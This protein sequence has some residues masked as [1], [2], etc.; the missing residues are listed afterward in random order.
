MLYLTKQVL[1]FASHSWR[2]FLPAHMPVTILYS[3]QVAKLLGKLDKLGR[4]WNP[5]SMLG[6]IG[7]TRWFL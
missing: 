5:D 7:T 6:R 3:D 4:R 1:W 2:S